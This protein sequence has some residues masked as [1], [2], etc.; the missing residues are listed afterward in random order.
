MI[1]ISKL[2][3]IWFRTCD[4][5]WADYT[6]K[7]IQAWKPYFG[8]TYLQLVTIRN[9]LASNFNDNAVKSSFFLYRNVTSQYNDPKTLDAVRKLVPDDTQKESLES[10]LKWFK[11]FMQWMPANLVC[12]NCNSGTNNAKDAG[13]MQRKIEIGDSWKIL[14]T[15]VYTCNLC[16]AM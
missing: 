13:F 6:N 7:N 2:C 16:G 9:C 10:L 11:G 5:S 1:Q 3:E 12:G 4:R 14:K 15:E 8:K